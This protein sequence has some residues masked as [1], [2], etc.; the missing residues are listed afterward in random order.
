MECTREKNLEDCACTYPGCSRAGL[1]CVC[2]RYHR[3]KQQIPGCFFSK[4][5]EKTFDRSVKNFI[6]DKE[7]N[8]AA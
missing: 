2:V 6:A 8:P 3:E 5:G 7:K 1:C 4:E